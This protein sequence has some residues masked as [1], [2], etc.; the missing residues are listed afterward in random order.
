MFTGTGQINMS[1]DFGI[2][3]Y[4]ICENHD[5]KNIIEVGTWNGQ[6]STVCVMNAILNKPGSVLY[7]IEADSYQYSRAVEYWTNKSTKNKLFLINGVLHREFA[8]EEELK[9][10]NNG[11][12]PY[13]YEHYIPEKAMLEHNNIIDTSYMKDIDVI[14]LDGGEFT[15][16]GDYKA[17]IQKNPKVILLDDSNVYKCQQIRK[18]LLEN[19][20]WELFKENLNDRNGWTIF[21]KKNYRGLI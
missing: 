14:I 4:N 6:G 12:I 3:I 19:P 1:S 18:E 17:L 2:E 13:L 21:V 10:M 7:S 11:V 16:Y 15:T 8:N 5:I 20:E 9:S